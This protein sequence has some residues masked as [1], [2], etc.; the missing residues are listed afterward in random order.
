MDPENI[1]PKN[2]SPSPCPTSCIHFVISIKIEYM[3]SEPDITAPARAFAALGSP[4]RLAILRRLV[5]AGPEGL[6]MGALGEAVGVMGSV[7]THHV[8]DLADAG[9]V[10]QRR[11]GRRI[12]CSV[13]FTAL[14]TLSHFLTLECC[15]DVQPIPEPN[16]G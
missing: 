8:R 7:L 14:E 3:N 4:H 5:R 9:L 2:K 12:F 11:D 10:T 15:I 6:P 16:H 13:D 1:G